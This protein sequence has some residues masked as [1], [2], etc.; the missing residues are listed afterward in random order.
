M[1]GQSLSF[2]MLL[3]TSSLLRLDTDKPDW[4][5]QLT[6]SGRFAHRRSYV[7]EMGR[8]Y[9]LQLHHYEPLLNFR[10]EG[11]KGVSGHIFVLQKRSPDQEL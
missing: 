8:A 1:L 2:W 9:N 4:R 7:E 11:G 6:P 3:L 5:W 10:Y